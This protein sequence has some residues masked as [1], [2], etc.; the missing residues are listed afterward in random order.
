MEIIKSG[1]TKRQIKGNFSNKKGE[2]QVL[3][4]I[5]L[6][7]LREGQ[8]KRKKGRESR[9]RGAKVWILVRNFV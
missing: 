3:S 1:R 4:L 6:R 7:L 8:K 5:F 9:T 2:D